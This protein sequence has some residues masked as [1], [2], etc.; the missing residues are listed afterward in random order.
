MSVNEAIEHLIQ[1]EQLKQQQVINVS[2]T[3]AIGISRLGRDVNRYSWYF[4]IIINYRLWSTIT[5]I[6]HLW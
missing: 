1:V 3:K 6:S 2:T 5:F 4:I